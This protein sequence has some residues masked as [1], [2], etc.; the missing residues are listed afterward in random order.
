MAIETKYIGTQ[1]SNDRLSQDEETS[2][3]ETGLTLPSGMLWARSLLYMLSLA[4]G[5]LRVRSGRQE[6][7]REE[8]IEEEKVEQYGPP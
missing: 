1:I 3:Y 4:A 8:K 2:E 5:P 7:E 6:V